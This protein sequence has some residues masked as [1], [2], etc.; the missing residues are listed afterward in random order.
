MKEIYITI[1]DYIEEKYIT[2][3]DIPINCIPQIGE[4]I[5]IWNE[6]RWRFYQVTE[7]SKTI[8]INSELELEI[9]VI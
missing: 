9:A 4:E 1:I 6:G 7:V 3:L 2:D 8:N 5:K